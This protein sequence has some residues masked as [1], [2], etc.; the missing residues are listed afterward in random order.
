[1][2]Y[3]NVHGTFRAQERAGFMVIKHIQIVTY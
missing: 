2:V 1:M 3:E